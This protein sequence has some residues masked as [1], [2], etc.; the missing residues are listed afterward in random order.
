MAHAYLWG[1][2]VSAFIIDYYR[3]HAMNKENAKESFTEQ[4]TE[5]MKIKEGETELDYKLDQ[6]N[7]DMIRIKVLYW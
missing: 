2:L 1:I 3:T 4:V 6:Q 7:D 5:G